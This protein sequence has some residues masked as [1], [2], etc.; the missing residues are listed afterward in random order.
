M[1]THSSHWLGRRYL[2]R[3]GKRKLP[4][5][6]AML[7]L[8]SVAGIM[9]GVLAA[10]Q[11][12]MNPQRFAVA[13]TVLLIPA[14]VGARL[15]YVMQYAAS[16]R[17]RR[18]SIFR[19]LDAGAA[20]DGG[21]VLSVLVSIPVLALADLPFGEFWD[22]ATL[23]LLVGTIVARFGCLMNGCCAGRQTNGPLGAMLPNFHGKWRRRYP[24]P[25]MEACLSL[26]LL[27]GALYARSAEPPSGTLFA[28]TLI[29]Y[30]IGRPLIAL[31][32]ETDDFRR[33]MRISLVVTSILLLAGIAMLWIQIPAR[34]S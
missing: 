26:A 20:Q 10:S 30:A 16:F 1:S 31:T 4:S 32:R 19:P 6:T 18:Q 11:S 23:T 34:G 25:V 12:G 22:A 3:I 24:T 15:W 28:G 2:C 29:V 9:A 33:M 13:A 14:L 8:G 17:A 27:A 21:L 5:F 7:Y